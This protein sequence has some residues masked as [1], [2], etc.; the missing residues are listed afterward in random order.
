MLL[1]QRIRHEDMAAKWRNEEYTSIPAA[2]AA[3]AAA[4]PRSGR[5]AALGLL[6]PRLQN[7]TR[8]VPLRVP[9]KSQG[10]TSEPPLE[11]RWKTVG[12]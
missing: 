4:K 12:K 2:N 9:P 10:P 1:Q 6:R 11:L 8:G 5:P 7:A 3:P